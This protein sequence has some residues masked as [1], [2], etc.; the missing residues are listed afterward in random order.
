M[1]PRYPARANSDGS[2]PSRLDEPQIHVKRLTMLYELVYIY[3]LPGAAKEFWHASCF[4][5]GQAGLESQVS[6]F[7][8]VFRPMSETKV[9]AA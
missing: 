4:F 1:V 2:G 6:S 3:R 8:K 7:C 9:T 5:H